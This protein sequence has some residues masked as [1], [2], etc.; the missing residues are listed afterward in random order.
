ML[1]YEEASKN[2]WKR[3]TRAVKGRMQF[4]SSRS[5]SGLGG[6]GGAPS[7]GRHCEWFSFSFLFLVFPIISMYNYYS[8]FSKLNLKGMYVLFN[9]GESKYAKN[10]H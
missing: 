4:L 5:P 10:K 9:N 1:E 2:H 7:G 6:G 3:M 8:P